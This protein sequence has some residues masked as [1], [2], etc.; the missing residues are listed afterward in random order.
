MN[1]VRE[2]R[3]FAREAPQHCRVLGRLIKET[4]KTL[5]VE[6]RRYPSEEVHTFRVMKGYGYDSRTSEPRPPQYHYRYWWEHSAQ[7][8]VEPCPR[9]ED[10]K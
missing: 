7:I 9:C 6:G 2:T 4:P 8:H 1:T 3:Y 10:Y 5:L